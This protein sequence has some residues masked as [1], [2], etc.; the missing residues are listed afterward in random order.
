MYSRVCQKEYIASILLFTFY[1]ILYCL[2]LLFS[3]FH[4]YLFSW[5]FIFVQHFS[6]W[7]YDLI[8]IIHY[9]IEVFGVTL[10]DCVMVIYADNVIIYLL[11]NFIRVF[12]SMLVI[13]ALHNSFHE[14]LSVTWEFETVIL[15]NCCCWS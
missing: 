9:N 10:R 7:L 8:K 3:C 13:L 1:L 14:A 4:V 2:Q 11:L 12:S 15:R 6:L 5:L